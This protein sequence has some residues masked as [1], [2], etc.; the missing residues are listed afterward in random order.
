[1]T[2]EHD[3]ILDRYLQ[4]VVQMTIL[5]RFMWRDEW[6]R[7]HG[8]KKTIKMP[9]GGHLLYHD[10]C[11]WPVDDKRFA[12]SRRGFLCVLGMGVVT[13]DH[14]GGLQATKPSID[15][16]R[17]N[18]ILTECPR[19]LDSLLDQTRKGKIEFLES[20]GKKYLDAVVDTIIDYNMEVARR[21]GPTNGAATLDM[22]KQVRQPF[23]VTASHVLKNFVLNEIGFMYT[24]KGICC[25]DNEDTWVEMTE[26][27]KD[28]FSIA[29]QTEEWKKRGMER[30]VLRGTLRGPSREPT[31]DPTPDN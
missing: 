26:N 7:R 13:V 6:M 2:S 27:M 15:E 23:P 18:M 3:K 1:M 28:W 20:E 31:S 14:G 4:F 12:F 30:G 5:A 8:M 17:L 9:D 10:G 22:Y 19:I 29:N 16:D 21:I 24:V 25:F 11:E